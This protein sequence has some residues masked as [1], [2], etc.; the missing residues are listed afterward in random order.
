MP[1]PD[2]PAIRRAFEHWWPDLQKMLAEIPSTARHEVHSERELLEEVLEIVRQS[3]IR[4]LNNL[5][6]QILLLPNV[7]SIEVA[8]KQV[9][10]EV[11]RRLA[12]RITVTRK[13]P[14]AQIPSDQLIPSS[15]FGMPTDVVEATQQDQAG[16]AMGRRGISN[17]ARRPGRADPPNRRSVL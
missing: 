16:G 5:L 8:S 6:G 1:L 13:L 9:A 3:G 7:R 2:E 12:L 17:G 10:G 15:I 14:L 11:M 4:D